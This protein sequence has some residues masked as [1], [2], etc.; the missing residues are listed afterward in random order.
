MV[1]EGEEGEDS[2]SMLGSESAYGG[3]GR[4]SMV[5]TIDRWIQDLRTSITSAP[6]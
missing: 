3:S 5:S 6:L 1:L 2:M 4:S